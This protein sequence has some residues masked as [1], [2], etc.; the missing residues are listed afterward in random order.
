[1]IGNVQDMLAYA[2]DRGL[3]VSEAEAKIAMVKAQDYLATFSWRGNP[4]ADQDEPWPRTGLVYTGA[5]L[6]DIDGNIITGLRDGQTVGEA[7]TP[8]AIVTALYRLAMED[9]NGNE[10]MPT[11]GGAEVLSESI[12]GAVSVT[13]AA[14]T[15]G[16]AVNLPWFDALVQP[17]QRGGFSLVNFNVSR[18]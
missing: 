4:P 16:D 10:L 15:V 3:E 1:M 2:A 9:L 17:W 6:L 11:T 5:A 12:S 18:G 14:G 7:A 8:R 13:Y